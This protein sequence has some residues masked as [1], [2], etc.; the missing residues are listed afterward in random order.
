MGTEIQAVCT[1]WSNI[2]GD[3]GDE[4][5][6]VIMLHANLVPKPDQLVDHVVTRSTSLS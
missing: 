3:C 4:E 5:D 2:T 6:A 1:F